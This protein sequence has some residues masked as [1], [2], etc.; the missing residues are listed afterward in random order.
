M[1]AFHLRAQREFRDDINELLSRDNIR[2]CSK[3]EAA[4]TN[5]LQDRRY[6]SSPSKQ[7]SAKVGKE[8]RLP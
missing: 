4:M 8:H 3:K 7:N 6:I 5:C 1:P 2:S